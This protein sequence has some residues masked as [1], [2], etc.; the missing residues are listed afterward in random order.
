MTTCRHCQAEIV[1]LP[2]FAGRRVPF[3]AATRPL[4]AVSAGDAYLVRRDGVAVPVGLVAPRMVVGDPR[5]A[6]VHRCEAYA[7]WR[8]GIR[9]AVEGIMGVLGG[10]SRDTTRD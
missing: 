3:E 2:T 10:E 9:P 1:W 8:D 4:S 5:V 7:R 6:C